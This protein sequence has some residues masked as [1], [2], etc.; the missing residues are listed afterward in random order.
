MDRKLWD[1]YETALLIEAYWKIENKQG[2]REVV[3]QNLSDNLRK[4][5][6]NLGDKVDDKFRNYN[7]M[8]FM[9]PQ[10]KACFHPELYPTIRKTQIFGDIVKVYKTDRDQFDSLLLEAHNQVDGVADKDK[11]VLQ[12]QFKQW[13]EKNF[14]GMNSQFVVT[15]FEKIS[16]Y[17]N[18][19]KLIT[20]NIFTIREIENFDSLCHKLYARKD[21]KYIHHSLYKFLIKYADV[22]KKYLNEITINSNVESYSKNTLD[23][24][25]DVSSSD[26][27]IEEIE[28][29]NEAKI[30]DKQRVKVM[31]GESADKI[32]E[33]KTDIFIID[34]SCANDF[35]KEKRRPTIDYIDVIT[36]T[37]AEESVI[38]NDIKLGYKRKD[39]PLYKAFN[40]VEIEQYKNKTIDMICFGTRI[41]NTLIRHKIYTIYELLQLSIEQIISWENLGLKSLKEMFEKMRDY[42]NDNANKNV[43]YLIDAWLKGEKGLV[44]FLT[45]REKDLYLQMRGLIE[46]CGKEF[47]NEMRNNPDY[48]TFLYEGLKDYYTPVLVEFEKNKKISTYYSIP[49]EVRNRPVKLAYKFYEAK[50][51]HKITYLCEANETLTVSGLIEIMLE[52]NMGDQ[53]QSLCGFLQWVK[54]ID[55]NSIVKEIFSRE[56]LTGRYAINSEMLDKYWFVFENRAEGKVLENISSLIDL[57]RERVRQIEERC[58]NNFASHYKSTKNDLLASIYIQYNLEDCLTKSKAESILGKRNSDILWLVLSKGVLDCDVYRYSKKYNI[59]AFLDYYK[60]DFEESQYCLQDMLQEIKKTISLHFSNGIDIEKFID[61]L[62]LKQFFVVD[63]GMELALSDEQIKNIVKQVT[64]E[65]ENKNFVILDEVLE[66][67]SVRLKELLEQQE[68]IFYFENLFNFDIMWYQENNILS[69]KMLYQVVK[70]LIRKNKDD[71]KQITLRQNYFTI[72]NKRQELTIIADEIDRVWGDN[73]LQTI[74]ELAEKLKYIPVEKLK[75]SLAYIDNFKWN[76]RDTY[77]NIKHFVCDE[78]TINGIIL[79]AKN[80]CLS[81]GNVSF[82]E[83]PLDKIREDNFVM[84]DYAIF[85]I[86]YDKIKS[87]FDRHLNMLTLKGCD[88][89]VE[90]QVKQY[91]KDHQ[92]CTLEEIN[93]IIKNTIGRDD[94]WRAIDYANLFMV[95][96]SADIFVSPQKVNFN[97]KEIDYVLDSMI[98]DDFMGMK[99]IITYVM[100]PYCNYQWNA[101]LL[102]S[103]VRSYS[104]NYKYIS[105]S[106]NSKNVGA[107]VRKTNTESYHDIMVKAV[108]RSYVSADKDKI[109]DFLINAGYLGKRT[110]KKINQL[111]KEVIQRRENNIV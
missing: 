9:L 87:E 2:K 64:I 99:E 77:A 93:E 85:D 28:L 6:I 32:D 59:V 65:F 24:I 108:A 51:Q 110:Y 80:K 54:N 44:E 31:V 40:I 25:N 43:L 62:K 101:F 23:E 60:N 76:S 16:N 82:F 73:A 107:I 70:E 47:Y 71:F 103:F 29:N 39:I 1:K 96:I 79:F 12:S 22:Y 14:I 33:Q 8:T 34:E 11:I 75:Y 13:L 3:L 98:Q 61:R 86:I 56:S 48:I 50:T 38:D 15:M 109:F 46:I 89:N 97:V 72:S 83:L 63:N 5:A 105:L 45:Q 81:D 10:I 90:K 21:F 7:G 19:K 104:D 84:T 17:V 88:V 95:R 102:E 106:S 100:F 27:G 92:E 37:Q 18:A 94:I 68:N 36:A 20:S 91:C 30:I 58:V 49:D 78:T 111:I 52:T 74:D 66:N 4:R 55:V 69:D 26:G 41:V 42:F 53:Y 67:I 35:S 57:T